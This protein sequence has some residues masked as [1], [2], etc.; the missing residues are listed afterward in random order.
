MSKTAVSPQQINEDFIELRDGNGRLL[1]RFDPSRDLVE[2]KPKGGDVV[3]VDLR[4]F[5]R[6]AGVFVSKQGRSV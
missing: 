1:F 4:P 5:R 2:I 6:R 3:L